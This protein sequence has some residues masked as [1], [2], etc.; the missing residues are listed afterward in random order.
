MGL[1]LKAIPV[2]NV[3]MNKEIPLKPC[4]GCNWHVMYLTDGLCDECVEEKEK[5]D[6]DGD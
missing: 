2:Y 4:D 1:T 5:K 3:G 6:V